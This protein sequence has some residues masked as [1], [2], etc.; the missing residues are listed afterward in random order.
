MVEW[1]QIPGFPNYEASDEGDIRRIK[2]GRIL[3]K[4]KRN[5]R[6]HAVCI[7]GSNRQVSRLVYWAF[8]PEFEFD[9]PYYVIMHDDMDPENDELSNLVAMDRADLIYEVEP[10]NTDIWPSKPKGRAS[11]NYGLHHKEPKHKPIL[12][13]CVETGTIFDSARDAMRWLEKK[14][15]GDCCIGYLAYISKEGKDDIH[16]YHF[17][18]V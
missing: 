16:G 17:I 8:H 10:Y 3:S 4:F 13:K 9:D 7:G 18:R 15:L 2:T 11:I 5:G 14:G 6:S 1:R 12:I